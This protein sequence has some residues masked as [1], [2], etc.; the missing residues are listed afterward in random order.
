MDQLVLYI[1]AGYPVIYLVTHEENRVLRFLAAATVA[2]R[3]ADSKNNR[4]Q[5]SKSLFRYREGRGRGLQRVKNCD[6]EENAGTQ[7]QGEGEP[8]VNDPDPG[9]PFSRCF[10]PKTSEDWINASDRFNKLELAHNL[11]QKQSCRDAIES[12]V[13][14]KVTNVSTTDPSRLGNSICVFFDIHGSLSKDPDGMEADA[15][16]NPIPSN[17]RTVRWAA[18]KLREDYDSGAATDG[19]PYKT[20]IFVG[21]SASSLSMELERDL[22]VMDFP[23]P[24]T[25][26]LCKVLNPKLD[27]NS[28]E[29][30]VSELKRVGLSSKTYSDMA[31]AGRGLTLENYKRGLNVISC[32]GEEIGTDRHIDELHEIKGRSINN[33]ALH[34]TPRVDVKLGG[35]DKA[36]TWI[37]GHS[38]LLDENFRLEYKLPAPKGALLF[39]ASGA[40]KSQMARLMA[41]E[42]GMPLL[43]LDVGALFGKYVGEAEERTRR[44]LETAEILAP[45]VLWLDEIDKSF[46]GISD[47]GDNGVSARVFGHFLTWLAEKETPVFVAATANNHN[48]ILRD[49]PEFARP[50]RFDKVFWVGL[51]D[52]VARA[53]ILKIK[54]EQWKG[55]FGDTLDDVCKELAAIAIDM[56]GAELEAA[57]YEAAKSAAL[58]GH[59]QL[60]KE[61]LQSHIEWGAKR[62][63][64]R[65]VY[66]GAGDDPTLREKYEENRNDAVTIRQ[67]D[68]V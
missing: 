10:E 38:R 44:A 31:G 51:P 5:S 67:W 27:I 35:L 16:G 1:R 23:L 11:N 56:T 19:S 32:R 9:N 45:I 61:R 58:E 43:R 2:V 40:G 52:Q 20:L 50:G 7:N 13:D 30:L 59:L 65:M 42:F 22:V 18:E 29:D 8:A 54:L 48:N 14:A 68:E 25:D 49:F 60:T 63:M 24:E 36:I 47:G 39:G 17:V 62:A 57:V 6:S 34:F 55:D 37:K 53:A 4:Q 64:Y 21:P 15:A 41:S 12:V 66:A 3:D 33:E 28:G 46:I 26:E